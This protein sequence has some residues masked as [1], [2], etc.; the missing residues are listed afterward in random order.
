MAG[1]A[2]SMMMMMMMMMMGGSLLP[3]ATKKTYR[4]YVS[5]LE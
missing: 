2:Q 5:P 4:W 3:G 1:V